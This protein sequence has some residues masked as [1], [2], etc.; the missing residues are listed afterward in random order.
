MGLFGWKQL[1]LWSLEH[2]CLSD[3]ERSAVVRDWEQKW[4]EFVDWVIKTYE[5]EGSLM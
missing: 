5:T 4:K 1:V 2:A 3:S